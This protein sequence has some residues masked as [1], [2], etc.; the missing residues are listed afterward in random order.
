VLKGTRQTG[1]VLKSTSQAGLVLQSTSQVGQVRVS[2]CQAVLVLPSTRR[3]DF[4]EMFYNINPNWRLVLR[5]T[6]VQGPEQVP[7]MCT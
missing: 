3:A 2:T 1:L 4:G 6:L 7:Q 5:S